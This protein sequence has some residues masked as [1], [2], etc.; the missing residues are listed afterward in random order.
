[1]CF[2]LIDPI[3]FQ[4]VKERWIPELKEHAPKVPF[5]L[6]GL[7]SDGR[8]LSKAKSVKTDEGEAMA[9]KVGAKCYVECSACTQVTIQPTFLVEGLPVS[10]ISVFWP[11]CFYK[12]LYKSPIDLNNRLL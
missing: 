9:R 3:S 6:V 11:I 1:M 2:N 5:I 4:N 12:T 10:I 7:K 8:T